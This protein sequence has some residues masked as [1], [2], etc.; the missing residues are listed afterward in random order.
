MY[1][2]R[3]SVAA[4]PETA[5]PPPATTPIQKSRLVAAALVT[6]PF[7]WAVKVRALPTAKRLLSAS[8]P[9]AVTY[10]DAAKLVLVSR[11]AVG[12]EGGAGADLEVALDEAGAAAQGQIQGGAA[13]RLALGQAEDHLLGVV[14]EE[15][16]GVPRGDRRSA[17]PATETFHSFE[18]HAPP[19]YACTSNVADADGVMFTSP[20]DNAHAAPGPG[21]RCPPARWAQP[22]SSCP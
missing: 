14:A 1:W 7:V 8:L 16:R 3:R 22:A 9:V 6:P 2:F 13:R 4:S 17:D 20:F 11:L 5:E 21:G 10:P 19:V 15:A 12:G 18:C